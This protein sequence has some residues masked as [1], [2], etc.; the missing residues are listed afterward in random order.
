MP[1]T[2]RRHRVLATTPA[3]VYRAQLLGQRDQAKTLLRQVQQAFR[4]NH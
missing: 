2:V 3:K 4:V 1:N